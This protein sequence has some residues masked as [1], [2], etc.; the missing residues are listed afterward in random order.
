LAAKE[1]MSLKRQLQAQSWINHELNEGK[2][3]CKAS[4]AALA[5]RNVTLEQLKAS[6]VSL[7]K[8]LKKREEAD[9]DYLSDK[10]G[11]TVVA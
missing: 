4:Y 6:M 9:A 11:K 7:Q 3:T 10:F 8:N 1:I 2:K 5:L